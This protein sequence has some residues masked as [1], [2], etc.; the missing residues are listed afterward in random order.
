LFLCLIKHYVLKIYGR[1]E[2]QL[3]AFLT[4]TPDGDEWSV[5]CLGHHNPRKEPLDAQKH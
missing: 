3:H 1:V 5:E 2:V 4:L